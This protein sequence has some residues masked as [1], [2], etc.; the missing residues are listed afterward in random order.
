[1]IDRLE[2]VFA[3]LRETNHELVASRGVVAAKAK[4]GVALAVAEAERDRL[5][6]II[7]DAMRKA[8]G[9]PGGATS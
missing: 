4:Q 8:D 3:M 5:Q 6:K 7:T 9:E 1:M 2:D